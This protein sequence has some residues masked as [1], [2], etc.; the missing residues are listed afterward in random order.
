MEFLNLDFAHSQVFWT[1]VSFVTLLALMAFKVTPVITKVLDE[2]AERIRADIESAASLK[3]EAEQALA[4][5]EKQVKTATAE[6]AEIVANARKEAED[7]AALRAKELSAELSRK[8]AE[9]VAQ[10]EN[11][12]K[13]AIEDLKAQVAEMAVL[14]TEKL[15][16]ETVDAAKASRI[17]DEAI[18]S[19]N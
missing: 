7:I 11:A 19:L 9:A 12:K 2:R 14:A 4:A 10:I 17:T 16:G 18:K 8:N 1:G 3:K 15:I 13:C 5:Y 6:A